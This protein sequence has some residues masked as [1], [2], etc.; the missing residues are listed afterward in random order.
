[1]A[2]VYGPRE[3]RQRAQIIHDKAIVTV[4]LSYA[5]FSTSER[6]KRSKTDKRN[7]EI[8]SAVKQTFEP[9]IMTNLFPKSQIDIFLQ[10]LQF[11]GG[12]TQICIN[13]A[14]L[15]LIDAGIPMSDYVCACSAGCIENEAIL[16]LNFT[17]ESYD[18]PELSVALLPKSD[19]VTLL[20]MES[21]LHVDKFESVMELA[22]KGCK[23]VYDALDQEVRSNMKE[24]LNKMSL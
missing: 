17:E 21:R 13:A 2:A 14:T 7:L 16:D 22:A 6:K 12:T 10:I 8:A 23:E 4:E 3:A 9:V 19:K 11:D 18:T 1:L 24:L 15:A 20:Q 5:P